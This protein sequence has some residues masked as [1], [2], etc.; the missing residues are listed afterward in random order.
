MF[1]NEHWVD[2]CNVMHDE[3]EQNKRL[4]HWYENVLDEMMNG[5]I[6]AITHVERTKLDI[7]RCQN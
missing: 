3:E 5:E 7:G 2:R 4:T 6:E 1:C